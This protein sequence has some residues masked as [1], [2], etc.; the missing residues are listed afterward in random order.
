MRRNG[1]SVFHI[2]PSHPSNRSDYIFDAMDR[3][4]RWWTIAGHTNPLTREEARDRAR[5]IIDDG[6][7]KVEM[8]TIV[9]VVEEVVS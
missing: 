4:G 6:Y 1:L 2:A 8:A 9:R 7:V 5:R 3:F